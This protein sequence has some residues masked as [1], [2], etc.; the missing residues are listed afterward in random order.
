MDPQVLPPQSEFIWRRLL[1]APPAWA[2]WLP[3]C[4]AVFVV[5]LL[6][7]FRPNKRSAGLTWLMPLVVLAVAF[8]GF[9]LN[10]RTAFRSFQAFFENQPD[11]NLWVPV[12]FAAGFLY[13]LALFVWDP[14]L[15]RSAVSLV[16]V[17]A[18]GVVYAL[19]GIKLF[20]GIFS[21]WYLLVPVVGI[22]LVYVGL[23]YR[24]DSRSVHPGIA[25]FLGLLRCCVYTI[26][27]GVFLLPGCQT[28]E[29]N[30][31]RSKVLFLFDVSESMQTK[32]GT[33]AAGQDPDTMETRQDKII[34]LLVEGN[35]GRQ[36]RPLLPA[37]LA[38]SPITGYRFGE[39]LDE[40]EISSWSPTEPPTLE[41]LTAWLNPDVKHFKAP[42]AFDPVKEP[43]GLTEDEI[44]KLRGKYKER[45]EGLRRGTNVFGS[46]LQM[47]KLEGN[48]YIQAVVVISDGQQNQG[49][50]EAKTDFINRITAGKK[51]V[52][53]FTIGVGEFRLPAEIRLAE[54]QAPES[55]RPD[56]KFP[57]RVPVIGTGLI[58]EEF[59]TILEMKRV[60]DGAGQPVEEPAIPLPSKK[61]K[62]TGAGDFPQDTVEFE[63]DLQELKNIKVG[64]EKDAEL[65]GTW[66]FV[67][68]VPRN[69]REVY[70]K[71]EHVS[72]TPTEVTIAKRKLRVLLFAGGPT[73][74]Y[75][76]LRTL[77]YR[78][79]TEKRME[80]SVLLQTGREDQVDQD[81]ESERLLHEFPK[82]IGATDPGEKYLSL[83]DYDVIVAV[84]PDWMML[85]PEQMK[86]LKE[87]VGAHSGGIVF[88][89]GPVYTYQLARPAGRDITDLKTL[90]PVFLSDSRLHGLGGI[91]H[92]ASR[93]Y[94]LR[95]SPAAKAF[96][97]LKL[98]E[99]EESVNFGWNRFFWGDG[100]KSG[101]PA[102]DR[103]KNGF[104]NYYPVEK[105]KAD[106]AVL[107]TFVGPDSSKIN[108]GK[109]E[110]PFMVSM[111]YG[112][113]KTFF[114]SSGEMY[115]LRKTRDAYHE[116]FWI[117]LAR[118]MS[119]GTIQQK[120]YGRILT[121]RKTTVGN[122]L[123]EAQLKGAD[124]LP[125]SPDEH[126]VVRVKRIVKEGAAPKDEVFDLKA[127]KSQ[128]EWAGWF[129]G[130]FR[131]REPGV[132]KF[133]IATPN[134]NDPLTA[135]VEVE[136]PNPERDNRRTNF[137]L[138]HSLASDAQESLAG[139]PAEVRQKVMR[140][141][142]TPSEDESHSAKD[143]PRL[144]FKLESADA[145]ADCLTVVPPREVSVKGKLF[146]LW[147]DGWKTGTTAS[148]FHLAWATPL[149]V[150]AFGALVLLFFRQVSFAMLFM[151]F[152][153][154]LALGVVGVDRIWAPT[155]PDLPLNFSFILVAI[156]SLLG[157][158]WLLRKLLKLA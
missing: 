101:D 44:N 57:V 122:I 35:K 157:I 114:L 123:V 109:D 148:A 115:R 31:Y 142:A 130:T 73:R 61:G 116:R 23:M 153:G 43:K 117:K 99:A 131:A 29:K 84:D 47:A 113:G 68:R 32:D 102:N 83:S 3:V 97:F 53:I 89:G 135:T 141:L 94:T 11:W 145:I 1:D 15:R 105:V 111:R 139:L 75:Q 155:W 87:W 21:W 4:F 27:A 106:S 67:A 156:A 51:G 74:E 69:P 42:P 121:S 64:T 119:S 38:K 5:W 110:Q 88:V 8:A 79:V 151:G 127:K 126:P 10:A 24:K 77:F 40:G 63:I 72:D 39:L 124:L 125:L 13:L 154:L 52:K 80:M 49:S 129:S 45:M 37:V 60:K 91:G 150:G 2:V 82:K 140:M 120:K 62:F 136:Q 86:M 14:A 28:Y 12:T 34:K 33:P 104:Y 6:A 56:D 59:D 103:P 76:F 112:N 118:S 65:E 50:D 71:A 134:P 26:L 20:L 66:Q 85:G 25:G 92:D 36:T 149:V 95:L 132:Y 19:A 107:A 96:D 9:L 48:N 137:A 18:I 108:D 81:V 90:L 78:E 55:A 152:G 46:A 17:S 133:E 147:D 98:E 54:L 58:D 138:L 41:Y 30:E 22:A 16:V 146:D 7:L 93:P 158:E 144:F 128:G 143:R 100:N 70:S